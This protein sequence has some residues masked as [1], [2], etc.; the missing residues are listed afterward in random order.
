MHNTQSFV[1]E[2]RK[3]EIQLNAVLLNA[4]EGGYVSINPETLAASYG[5][6]VE[7][8]IAMLREVTEICIAKCPSECPRGET[9]GNAIIKPMMVSVAARVLE[10]E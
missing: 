4:A 9:L 7:E 1:S 8:A 2:K 6:T 5:D 10:D 3:K